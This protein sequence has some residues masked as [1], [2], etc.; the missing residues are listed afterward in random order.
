MHHLVLLIISIVC[1]TKISCY[2]KES[3][4]ERCLNK[5]ENC[6]SKRLC[7]SR[8]KSIDEFC[9]RNAFKNGIF[10]N[11]TD[12]KCGEDK[13]STDIFD[14]FEDL[15]SQCLKTVMLYVIEN[16]DYY[17]EV[18]EKLKASV[19]KPESK[20]DCLNYSDR[21]EKKTFD[22]CLHEREE[23]IEWVCNLFYKIAKE[24]PFI[25][26]I[27][28]SS[29]NKCVTKSITRN[30]A[31]E[32]STTCCKRVIHESG[33]YYENKEK[34]MT[35]T[36][37]PIFFHCMDDLKYCNPTLMIN[38]IKTEELVKNFMNKIRKSVGVP[39][40]DSECRSNFKKLEKKFLKEC[41]VHK[42]R[43]LDSFCDLIHRILLE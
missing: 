5:F 30:F 14:C 10:D 13:I 36:Y 17:E 2:E 16:E 35:E 4:L 38:F 42:D 20:D 11:E 43:N 33:D 26:G 9:C 18:S 29:F 28:L 24:S 25:E 3:S 8:V 39:K 6:L 40:S 32:T 31:M 23:R 41:R 7:Y 37:H 27:C 34:C 12:E 19:K 1:A 21:L 22:M 15:D